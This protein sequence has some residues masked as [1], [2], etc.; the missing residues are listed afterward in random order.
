MTIGKVQ[1]SNSLTQA[2]STVSQQ[3]GA[4]FQMPSDPTQGGAGDMQS[5]LKIMA[6]MQ[7]ENRKFTLLSQI[8]TMRHDAAKSAA[9]NIH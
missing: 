1:G 8:L 2:T 9:K 3:Q 4:D 6:E 7:A 5:Y